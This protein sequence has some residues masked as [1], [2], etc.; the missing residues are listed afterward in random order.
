LLP[1]VQYQKVGFAA[2]A[3]VVVNGII[4]S[5][6]TKITAE[7]ISRVAIVLL[8][9]LY[10]NGGTNKSLWLSFG[11]FEQ[12]F[13][14]DALLCMH[15]CASTGCETIAIPTITAVVATITTAIIIITAAN[16]LFIGGYYIPNLISFSIN[17]NNLI[18]L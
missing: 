12:K 9:R 3:V 17:G 7:A 15:V 16:R 18:F 5:P 4:A 6:P 14:P 1:L 13:F 11:E 2:I 8:F 10:P